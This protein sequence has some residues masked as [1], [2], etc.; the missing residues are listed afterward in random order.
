M[1]AGVW[2]F[3][4][5]KEELMTLRFLALLCVKVGKPLVKKRKRI[6]VQ[7]IEIWFGD[8][9]KEPQK[10]NKQRHFPKRKHANS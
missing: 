7:R 5:E 2:G 3:N 10:I 8:T 4:Q 1:V 6:D 9:N